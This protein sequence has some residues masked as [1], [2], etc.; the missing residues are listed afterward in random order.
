MLRRSRPASAPVCSPRSRNGWPFTIVWSMPARR[1]TN[2]GAP[3]GKSWTISGSGSHMRVEVDHVHVGERAGAQHATVAV[4]DEAGGVGR[5]PAHAVLDASSAPR[6]RTQ[7]ERKNVG[8]LASMIWVAWA[9]ASASPMIV[10]GEAQQLGD[11]VE[12]LVEHRP[13]DDAPPSEAIERVEVELDGRD[14]EAAGVPAIESSRRTRTT[15][16]SRASSGT[17]G[18]TTPVGAA[19]LVDQSGR[20]PRGRGSRRAGRRRRAPAAAGTTAG[21]RS[22]CW[23]RG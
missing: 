1:W 21:G 9:P 13:V 16:R 3:P 12:V 20:G 23:R 17:C 7:C 2:R 22:A 11:R 18:R 15:R 14:A 5:E 10:T 8:W 4:A 6:S 19:A